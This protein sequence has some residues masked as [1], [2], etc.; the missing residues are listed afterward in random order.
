TNAFPIYLSHNDPF[1]I[2]YRKTF[3]EYEVNF[4]NL[5]W[6]Y[7]QQSP[8]VPSVN[9][10]CHKY[11]AVSHKFLCDNESFECDPDA[12]FDTYLEHLDFDKE[13]AFA[14]ATTV[15]LSGTVYIG[16]KQGQG[17]VATGCPLVGV[18]VC[19]HR[20]TALTRTDNDPM[21]GKCATTDDKGRYTLFPLVGTK[22]YPNVTLEGHAIHPLSSDGGEK[23][24]EFLKYLRGIPVSLAGAS[25]GALSNH[26]FVDTTQADVVVEVAGGTKHGNC[27]HLLGNATIEF[28]IDGC[29]PTYYKHD[30]TQTAV[31]A[32]YEVPA[33][34]INT[35]VTNLE[36]SN[37]DRTEILK[38]LRTIERHINLKNI[39]EVNEHTKQPQGD[40]DLNQDVSQA[41]EVNAELKASEEEQYDG[42]LTFKPVIASAIVGGEQI[43]HAASCHP[44]EMDFPIGSKSFHVLDYNT[45][46]KLQ[47][48][49]LQL[50]IPD[51]G[52]EC[53][54]VDQSTQ[55]RILNGVGLSEENPTE[56]AV[57]SQLKKQK[58]K[59][60]ELALYT[61]CAGIPCVLKVDAPADEA[62]EQSE[63]TISLILKAGI[64]NVISSS[65]AEY[66]FSKQIAIMAEGAI[67]HTMTV[68]VTG[69]LSFKPP[70]YVSFPVVKPFLVLRD[71]PGG[72]SAIEYNRIETTVKLSSESH[73]KYMGHSFEFGAGPKIESDSDVAI[74][75]GMAPGPEV[76]SG[77]LKGDSGA[78]GYIEHSVNSLQ[79][80]PFFFTWHHV[81]TELQPNLNKQLK[82]LQDEKANSTDSTDDDIDDQI[83]AVNASIQ[84]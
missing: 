70:R 45:D 80:A 12:G 53:A 68:V 60:N 49:L 24:I 17:I 9:F 73:E 47:V 14:D 6:D 13:I 25:N 20:L 41:A 58:N 33:H 74:G 22:V 56:K 51:E 8:V 32:N 59:A 40:S 42:T 44:Y 11:E 48:R 66:P 10:T 46:F 23:R 1:G 62:T 83:K 57:I 18:Q 15:P 78:L 2:S 84:G 7:F 69:D 63:S 21:V 35:R 36:S 4:S 76:E 26:D 77:V 19:I 82:Q 64:P 29:D 50:I 43:D 31:R 39:G 37:G 3:S 30:A 79:E 5:T 27:N 38:K 72:D 75:L 54:I 55:V 16:R 61:K 65:D 52:V 67:P 28:T 71:P 34:K 81:T